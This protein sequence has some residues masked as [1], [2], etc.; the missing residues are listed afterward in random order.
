MATITAS[1]VPI[2]GVVATVSGLEAVNASD[3]VAADSDN[4]FLHVHNGN[5][6]TCTVTLTDPG[7]TPAGSAATNPT[8]SITTATARLI[9]LPRSLADAN[10]FIVIGYSP[11]AS[12]QARAYKF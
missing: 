1:V 4:L 3:Q 12:V 7:R 6:G 11:T 10:G 9:K 5:A 8:V 2:T